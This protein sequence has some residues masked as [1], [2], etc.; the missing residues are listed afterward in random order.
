MLGLLCLK[1]DQCGAPVTRGLISSAL[2]GARGHFGFTHVR[3]FALTGP[4]SVVARCYV[5][6]TSQRQKSH[7]LGSE[8]QLDCQLR[9]RAHCCVAVI[10]TSEC[11]RAELETKRVGCY[12]TVK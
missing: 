7:C 12:H 6:L 2:H 4:L 1:K 11:S 10:A 9:R 5:S 8:P 3:A